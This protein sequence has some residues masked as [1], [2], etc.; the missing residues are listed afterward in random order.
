[1]R[2]LGDLLPMT[3]SGGIYLKLLC[4]PTADFKRYRCQ[5]PLLPPNHFRALNSHE[6]NHQPWSLEDLTGHL[7][8]QI[9]PV[10]KTQEESLLVGG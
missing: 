10:Q 9:A 5:G 4:I 7:C 8:P 3:F 2:F 1:M 6:K